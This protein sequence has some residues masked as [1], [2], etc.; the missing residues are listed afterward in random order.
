MGLIQRIEEAKQ[1][2][3]LNISVQSGTGQGFQP[4]WVRKTLDGQRIGQ[5][6]I[7]EDPK[8]LPVRVTGGRV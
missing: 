5:H 8:G 3:G 1:K 4:E 7:G 2:Q 6:R